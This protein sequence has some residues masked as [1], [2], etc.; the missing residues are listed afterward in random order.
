MTISGEDL[1]D[2]SVK[3]NGYQSTWSSVEHLYDP[4]QGSENISDPKE[5]MSEP[6]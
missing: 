1:A 6:E 4:F 2:H 3:N 5:Q